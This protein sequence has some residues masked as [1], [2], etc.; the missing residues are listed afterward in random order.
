MPFDRDKVERWLDRERELAARGIRRSQDPNPVSAGKPPGS[1]GG[2]PGAT[3]AL[4]DVDQAILR[5]L[6]RDPDAPESKMAAAAGVTVRWVRVRLARMEQL[7]I[8]ERIPVFERNDDPNWKARN[9]RPEFY[10][11]QTSNH[12]RLRG[13]PPEVPPGS[14]AAKRPSSHQLAPPD[15]A[16]KKPKARGTRVSS[17]GFPRARVH[18][19]MKPTDKQAGTCRVCGG[20]VLA[21]SAWPDCHPACHQWPNTGVRYGP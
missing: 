16:L 12:Y 18:M 2:G 1:V 15:S 19:D 13:D 17:K 20:V 14:P 4:S 3:A 9:R 10:G 21:S 7:G 8:L 6:E 5:V 11:Q